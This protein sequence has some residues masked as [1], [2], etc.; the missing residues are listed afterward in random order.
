MTGMELHAQLVE[1][2]PHLAG[3]MIFLTGGAFTPAGERS[4]T[5]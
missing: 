2:L 5:P 1:K 4:S 3:I